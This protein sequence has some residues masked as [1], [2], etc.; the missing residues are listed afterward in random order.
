MLFN[1]YW[2]LTIVLPNVF[3]FFFSQTWVYLDLNEGIYRH[4]HFYIISCNYIETQFQENLIVFPGKECF[5]FRVT[6]EW[7]SIK[8]TDFFCVLAERVLERFSTLQQ[9]KDTWGHT[10]GTWAPAGGAGQDSSSEALSVPERYR[11]STLKPVNYSFHFY[12]AYFWWMQTAARITSPSPD[13]PGTRGG[14]NPGDREQKW[15]ASAACSSLP[16]WW[17]SHC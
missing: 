15:W 9:L 12:T 3:R 4:V 1:N 8:T 13:P 6:A 5:S 14:F 11:R 16:P 17:R 7:N 2:P 10:E